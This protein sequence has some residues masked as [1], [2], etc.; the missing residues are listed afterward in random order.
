[1]V[2]QFS[3]Y[4]CTVGGTGFSRDRSLAWSCLDL[5]VCFQATWL[6]GGFSTFVPGGTMI[7]QAAVSF[8]RGNSAEVL[9]M[10][11]VEVG[12]FRMRTWPS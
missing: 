3:V 6:P 10:L 11:R 4:V 5:L 9:A 2:C 12:S 8:H 1:M 7:H